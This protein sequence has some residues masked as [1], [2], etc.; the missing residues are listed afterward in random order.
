MLGDYNIQNGSINL[1]A[2]DKWDYLNCSTRVLNHV[3]EYIG[4]KMHGNNTLPKEGRKY[5]S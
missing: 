4:G 1:F 2:K 5:D 3:S